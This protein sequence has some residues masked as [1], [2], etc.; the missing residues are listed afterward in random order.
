LYI[1]VYTHVYMYLH[2]LYMIRVESIFHPLN[3]Y[4][5]II[6][7]TSWENTS[8]TSNR[9]NYYDLIIWWR[10]VMSEERGN[11]MK[12]LIT[13]LITEYKNIYTILTY[14]IYIYTVEPPYSR[15][16]CDLVNC[17]DYR[18]CPLIIYSYTIRRD[19][20]REIAF[21]ISVLAVC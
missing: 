10:S 4:W 9:V 19:T 6:F 14:I 15:H 2:K 8:Y 12:L 18:G 7:N 16:H 3:E 13:I 1:H 17:P 5:S 11:K 21:S 20:G